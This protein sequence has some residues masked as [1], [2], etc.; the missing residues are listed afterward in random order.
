MK[1]IIAGSRG[2]THYKMVKDTMNNL[3]LNDGIN[4]I[5]CGMAQGADMLGAKWAKEHHIA[6]KLFRAEWSKHGRR[7][8]YL[9]NV[10]MGEYADEAI[11]FWDGK[12]RGSKMMI[13]IMN[14][15]NKPVTVVRY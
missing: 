15:L 14:R 10:D 11:V 6:I 13:D 3:P 5:V 12:S 1:M 2:F 8:G 9:R 4:E 7:A